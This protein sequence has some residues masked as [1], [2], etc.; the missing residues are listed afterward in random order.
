MTLISNDEDHNWFWICYTCGID[1]P[2]IEN[3]YQTSKGYDPFWNEEDDRQA[4][5][6]L[7]EYFYQKYPQFIKKK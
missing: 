2:Y 1:I 3:P 7:D 6:E 5:E 4:K